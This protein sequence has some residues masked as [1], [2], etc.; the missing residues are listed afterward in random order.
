MIE[1]DL[2]SLYKRAFGTDAIQYNA[3]QAYEK[4]VAKAAYDL[5]TVTDTEGGEFLRIRKL[6]G[7]NFN[8]IEI[9]MPVQIG[10]YLLPNEPLIAISSRKVIVETA[11]ASN[12]KLGTVK[13][14][15]ALNDYEISI[16]GIAI[17][18][19]GFKKNYPEKVVSE[20][21]AL[22]RRNEALEIVCALT[23]ILGIQKIVIKD[24]FLPEMQGT[25]NAQAYQFNAVSD[26]DFKL[27][28]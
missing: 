5:P 8:G 6:I 14:Q 26:N 25:Q 3:A 28:L 27:I 19:S 13:E 10:G 22:Y 7:S 24:F 9:F 1:F 15:I 16:K 17:D 23:E 11:L 21:N 4:T 12:V 2:Q 18:N 20:L